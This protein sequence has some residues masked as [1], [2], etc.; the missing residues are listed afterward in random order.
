MSGALL[1]PLRERLVGCA[2]GGRRGDELALRRHDPHPDVRHHDGPEHRP[3]VDICGAPAQ[4]ARKAVDDREQE[5]PGNER[6]GEAG[7][8]RER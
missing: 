2:P 5:H 3:R 4:H 7:A 8:A 1:G 6:G